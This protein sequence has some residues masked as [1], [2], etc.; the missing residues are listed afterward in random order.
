[1]RAGLIEAVL[2]D[3]LWCP[4]GASQNRSLYFCLYPEREIAIEASRLAVELRRVHELDGRPVPPERLHISLNGLGP[5]PTFCERTVQRALCAIQAVRMQPFRIAL[6][7]AESWGRGV[8]KRP[9]VLVGDDGMEGVCI[10]QSQIQAAL[11][12]FG[13]AHRRRTNFSPHM[14]LLRDLRAIR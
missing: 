13:V 9:L 3:P 7:C 8:T 10:L 2:D 14:T 1:M 12:D 5:F 4:Q 11:A 6:N